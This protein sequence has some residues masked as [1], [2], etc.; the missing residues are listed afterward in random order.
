[1]DRAVGLNPK[2]SA[3]LNNRAV[4]ALSP[5][6]AAEDWLT[7]AEGAE[8]LRR[9]LRQ[10]EFFVAAKVNLASLLNYYRVF[11]KSRER[12][13]QVLVKNPIPEAQDGLG[14]ALQGAGSSAAASESFRKATELGA[15]SSRFANVYHEAAREA[16]SSGSKCLSRLSDLSE[17]SLAGFEKDAVARL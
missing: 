16:A 8:L 5:E 14:V 13:A 7:A 11:R 6:G 9:A 17:G 10:D 3:A 12:W 2:N 15:S 4:V 1:Y